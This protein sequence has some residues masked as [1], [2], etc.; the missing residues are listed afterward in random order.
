MPLGYRIAVVPVPISVC[1]TGRAWDVKD[2]I[3]FSAPGKDFSY[4]CW[5]GNVKRKPAL[6]WSDRTCSGK[7]YQPLAL[8]FSIT[9]DL[10]A[11][12]EIRLADFSFF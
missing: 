9:R 7:T 5:S 8:P 3:D 11:G 12:E 4:V 2:Q 1:V 6:S 10:S